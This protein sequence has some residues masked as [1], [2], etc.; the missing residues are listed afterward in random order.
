MYSIRIVYY[1]SVCV[2]YYV[3]H[4]Q[5]VYMYSSVLYIMGIITCVCAFTLI[6]KQD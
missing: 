3:L 5:Y 1:T 2:L 4:V 6:N